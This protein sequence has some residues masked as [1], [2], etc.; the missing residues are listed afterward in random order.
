M[1]HCPVL[2]HRWEL[3]TASKNLWRPV[4]LFSCSQARPHLKLPGP[5]P[6]RGAGS[7][8]RPQLWGGGLAPAATLPESWQDGLLSS[9]LAVACS[10]DIAQAWGPLG[11]QWAG[12]CKRSRSRVA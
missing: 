12:R 11:L 5:S 8:L 10:N 2:Q 7:F 9:G 6:W 3:P 1:C 4:L